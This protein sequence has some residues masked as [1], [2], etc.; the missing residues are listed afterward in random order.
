MAKKVR[1]PTGAEDP[2]WKLAEHLTTFVNLVF[3]RR[4]RPSRA[5]YEA[6]ADALDEGGY[7]DAELRLA[8]WVARCLPEY[9]MKSALSEDMS[10]D[11]VLRFKGGMNA[12]TGKPSKKWLDELL[13]RASE[14]NPTIVGKVLEKLGETPTGAAMVDGERDLLKR[15]GVAVKSE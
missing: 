2:V 13:S 11:I 8:F 1:R 10:P 9:W 14:T 5:F 6:I 12:Q 3:G 7:T 4:L 15:M